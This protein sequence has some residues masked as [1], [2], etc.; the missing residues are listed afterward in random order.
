MLQAEG[1][2]SAKGLGREGAWP[3]GG[4]KE[5]RGDKESGPFPASNGN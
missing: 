2:V 3:V 1:T 4:S 5:G